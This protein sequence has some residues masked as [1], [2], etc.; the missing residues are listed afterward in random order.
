M[1]P[2]IQQE[3]LAVLSEIRALSPDVRLGQLFDFLGFMGE[4]HVG[5]RLADMEDDELLAVMYRHRADLMAR[6]QGTPD[7]AP[8]P[9]SAATSV[10]GSSISPVVSLA[11]A[12]PRQPEIAG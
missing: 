3:T 12:R 11:P 9:S 8:Q 5:H 7:K 6:I 10:S 2:E 1:M 4:I